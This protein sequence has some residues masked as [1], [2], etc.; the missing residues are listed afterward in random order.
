MTTTNA[1]HRLRGSVAYPAILLVLVVMLVSVSPALAAPITRSQAEKAVAA[2]LALDGR[3]LGA[4]MGRQIREV[5]SFTDDSDS[6][7]YFV[8]YLDPAGFVIVTAD[9]LVEP[10]IAFAPEGRYDPSSDNPLGALVSKDVPSRLDEVRGAVA[11]AAKVGRPFVAQGR[12]RVAR[13]KWDRLLRSSVETGT[14]TE[15]GLSG[16][17]DVRVAPFVLS[18]WDQIGDRCSWSSTY[19]YYIPP[20]TEGSISNYPAGCVATA[21]AQ[22]MRYWQFPTDGVGTASY[23]ISECEGAQ[24]PHPLDG[25]NGSGGPYVWSEMDLDPC[26]PDLATRQAIGH[27]CHDAGV[28]VNMNYCSGGSGADTL[29]AATALKNT[30]GYSSAKKGYNALS[31][32]PSAN[33]NSM[34]NPNLHARCPVILGIT[35]TPGGHAVVCDGY[36]YNLSTM[37]HHLNLGWSGTAT[38]W[39]NLPTI[40]TFTSVYK[41]IYNV[42]TSGTGEIIAGRVTD[43]VGTPISG[44]TVTATW[45]SSSYSDTTDSNGIYAVTKVNSGRTFS[46]SVTKSDYTF[47]SQQVTTGASTDYSTTC[48]NKWPIDFSAACTAPAAPTNPGATAI[49]TSSITWTWQD[50]SVDETGFKVYCDPGAGP[51]TTLQTTQPAGSGSWPYTGLSANTQYAFQVAATNNCGD[52]AKTTNLAKYTLALAPTYGAS[53]NGAVNCDKGPGSAAIWYPGGTVVTFSAVNGFGTG[54][55]KASSYLYVWDSSALE[56]SWTGALQWTSGSLMKTGVGTVSYLHLRSRNAEALVNTTTLLLGPYKVDG[57]TPT[58]PLVTDDGA[59]QIGTGQLH[60]SWSSSDATSGVGEYQ[61]AIGTAP[62]DPGSGYVVAWK[63]ASMNT[64]ATESGLSLHYGQAYYWY[65]KARDFAGNWSPTGSSDGIVVVAHVFA[66]IPSAKLLPDGSSVGL[67][68]PA[69]STVFGCT[70]Y[71]EQ[72]GGY[73]GIRV[74]CPS[75]ISGLVAGSIVDVG[76]RILTTTD[77]ER[78]IQGI[79]SIKAGSAQIRPVGLNNRCLG[80]GNWL[81]DSGTGAG[82][83]GVDR[84]TGVNNI[85]RV[86]RAWGK[87][88]SV[89]GSTCV[90]NDGSGVGVTLV[91]SSGTSAP[92]SGSIVSVTGISSCIRDGASKVQRCIRVAP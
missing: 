72:P 16:V 22:L 75:A 58:T 57:D 15:M 14:G 38:A 6:A 81:Y 51:P 27:L 87:V 41:C 29:Q 7:A 5:Q 9:D 85:G 47:T 43:S 73:V 62:A 78:Y 12:R 11:Q 67:D 66:G 34:I 20:N 3:P 90:I 24:Y 10:V 8:V 36:G 63:S 2:W 19:N 55:A 50:N 86:V 83:Q 18:K 45:A 52:S 82:Q 26:S 89:Q 42:Y 4:D 33:L 60:A 21:M 76:G 71:V 13:D 48:G 69:V 84:G 31:N 77:G 92:A 53:G 39:Y 79:A 56:P 46:V 91:Y 59:Y 68:S 40:D 80:G 23:N 65:V 64:Q 30:F 54:P 70:F 17:T 49:E 25:G 1:A 35:G 74:D 88:I 44:A 37:Y 61:Y 32:I 28:S